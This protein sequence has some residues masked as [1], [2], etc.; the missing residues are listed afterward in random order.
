MKNEDNE[1]KIFHN[2]ISSKSSIKKKKTLWVANVYSVSQI[3]LFI[4]LSRFKVEQKL[5]FKEAL[6][7]LNITEIFSGGCDLSGITGNTKNYSYII[8]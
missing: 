3:F 1:K 5:D 8:K 4:F 2:K 7:S 6:Y